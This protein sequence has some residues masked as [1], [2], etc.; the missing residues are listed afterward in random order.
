MLGFMLADAR[1]GAGYSGSVS[2]ADARM[3]AEETTLILEKRIEALELSCAALAQLLKDKF[4]VTEDE[5][6]KAIHDVDARDG[7]VDGKITQAAR[8]CP[9]CHRKVLTRNP[10]KCAWCGGNLSVM[11]G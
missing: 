7:V 10:T 11:G 1:L 8:V 4:N 6:L 2:Q 5:V 9:N 3:I